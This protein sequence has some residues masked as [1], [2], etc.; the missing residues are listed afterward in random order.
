M[1]RRHGA[2]PTRAGRRT[3]QAWKPDGGCRRTVG[4]RL[5]RRAVLGLGLGVT[6]LAYGVAG[7]GGQGGGAVGVDAIPGPGPQPTHVRA[8][9]LLPQA[10]AD[11]VAD[12]RRWAAPGVDA[13]GRRSVGTRHVSATFS[14]VGVHA[15]AFPALVR[16]IVAEGHGVCNHTLTHPEPFARRPAAEIDRRSPRPSRASVTP[17]ACPRTCSEP[18]VGG[19]AQSSSTR[20]GGTAWCHRLGCRPGSPV[21]SGEVVY[22]TVTA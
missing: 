12:D 11:A 5:S 22:E 8:H 14:V 20:P 4:G 21:T 17:P 13:A 9:H 3:L 18:R 10:P 2:S 7:C 15:R 6:T 19:G 16:R 1:P